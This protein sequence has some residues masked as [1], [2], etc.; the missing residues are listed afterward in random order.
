MKSSTNQTT[1]SDRAKSGR[2]L[3]ETVLER[4][5]TDPD[6]VWTPSD[7]VDLASRAAVDKVLQRLATNG[8]LRRIDRGLYDR[9]RPNR[10]TGKLAAPD[11]RAVVQAVARRDKARV[12][13]DGLTA[14]NDLGLT[15]AVPGRIRV[16]TDT[17]LK[18][19]RLGAQEIRFQHA[20]PSRLYWAD[21]PGM[22]VVQALHWLRDTFADPDERLSIAARLRSILRDS[23]RGQAISADLRA[24]FSVLPIWMQEFLRDL[25]AEEPAEPTAA[26]DTNENAGA[27]ASERSRRHGVE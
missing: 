19:I 1:A 7:F 14:A 10:L 27:S 18:P 13:V 25:L 17:R 21:R 26:R 24:G 2:S 16:L 3:R 15:N 5:R 20:A 6:A 8:E 9:P 12:L 11:Y 4:V 22:R 23:T